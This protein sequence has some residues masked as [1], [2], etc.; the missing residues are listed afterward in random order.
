MSHFLD[1]I[2]RTDVSNWFL[3]ENLDSRLQYCVL[4]HHRSGSFYETYS[5]V[6]RIIRFSD[7][8]PTQNAL[9]KKEFIANATQLRFKLRKHGAEK[10][11]WTR[12]GVIIRRMEKISYDELKNL[13]TLPNII[14]V[15]KSRRK[16]LM[17][18]AARMG[19]MINAHNV[20]VPKPE[21]KALP[22]RYR[23]T[24]E[25]NIKNRS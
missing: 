9:E 12:R 5:E 3:D 18:H 22:E 14:K 7:T 1:R 15:T 8:F 10:N 25:D 24:W 17:G 19:A 13:Y 2:Q 21:W 4:I 6:R 23:N 11:I 20:F 16:R